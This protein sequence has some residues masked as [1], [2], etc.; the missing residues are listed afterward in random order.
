MRVSVVTPS[1]NMAR[2]LAET[3]ASVLG[4]LAPGDEYLV[5]DG[6]STDGSAEI[7]RRHERH[8]AG[9]VSEPDR[10][11]ADALAKGFS[12]ASG[13]ILCWI[14]A[15]D[16]LL[17]GA[18]DAARKA[19]A[20]SGADMIFGDDF[21][22]DEEGRVILFSRGYVRDLRRAML[23]G[24]WT[25]LQDACF[26]RRSLYERV[27]GLDPALQYAA[28]YD[29]FLRMALAGR[30]AH[31]PVAFSAF[32]RHP[33][34]KS[35]AGAQRYGVERQQARARE[36]ARAPGPAWAKWVACGMQG[37]AVRWRVRVS[38]RRWVRPDLS[39]RPI[40]DLPSAAY[41]PPPRGA[42]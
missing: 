16:L 22:I 10:G 42:A 29:L 5:I 14:N 20:E 40:A 39:G 32:R 7:I 1:F 8:L 6:G 27:G 2:Y 30:A 35:I 17:A 28:D 23:F 12:R 18:L 9:W 31:V 33:G 21:Y 36:L 4:N 11:Y 25:P 13:D 34:Q 24:G 41:W 26:W 37:V 3:M 38:Q 15:G 19:I